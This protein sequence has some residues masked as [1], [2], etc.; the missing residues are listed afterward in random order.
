M[1]DRILIAN[2]GEIACRVIRTARRLGISTVAIYSDADHN[3]VHVGM[4]D[5]A[6]RIGPAPAAQSYLDIATIV[7]AARETGC[8]AVH[9][10]YGFVSENPAFAEA[11]R[12]AGITFIGPGPRAMEIM[13]D[14]IA[15]KRF[16][17]EAG[18]NTVPGHADVISDVE[19]AIRIAGD[20]GYPVMLKA[21]AGGGGKG[22]RVA[23]DEREVREGFPAASNEARSSFGDDRVFIEKF[24]TEPRHIEIQ[25]LADRHGN[26]LHLGERE[27][28]LQ[29]RNQKVIEE[30]PSVAV[31]EQ[32]RMEMGAQA[33]ALARA[34]G[35][36]SAGTVEFI[37]DGE[38]GFYFL[39][40][41]TRLQVEHTVT[42]LITGLDLVEQM[43]RIAA[44]EPLGFGQEEVSFSG[45][46]IEARVYAEDPSRNFL[47]SIGRLVRYQPPRE[48]TH[49][50]L[51][52]RNDGGVDEGGAIS[53]HYD[54]MISKLC[55]HGPTREAA[56]AHMLDALDRFSIVGI[57]HN[58]GFLA[59]LLN[60][61]RWSEGR[62][63]TKLIEEEFP[64]GFSGNEPDD[65]LARDL[66]TVAAAVDLLHRHHMKG[67]DTAHS[68]RERVVAIA[69]RRFDVVSERGQGNQIAVTID[70]ECRQV[71][72]NW[73]A[74]ALTFEATISDRPFAA[75][76]RTG[77]RRIR[78]IRRGTDVVARVMTRREAE[79]I[80]LMPEK[81]PPDTSMQLL[82]PM[83]GTVVTL[84]VEPGQE[85]KAGEVLCVV[86]AMKME[87]NLR[88]E[89][90]ATIARVLVQP[91]DSLAVDAVIM[92]FE[93]GG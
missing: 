81:L 7:A 75:Q 70:G 59:A 39:E 86:E 12:D 74:G 28:S 24:I 83:P 48:G 71:E 73:R 64:D 78:I 80:V 25:V 53:V 36:E 77:P 76:I 57:E 14:K 13:G 38:D 30:A 26:V 52:I 43:I 21:A 66:V 15:S 61:P 46:A 90:D 16:A 55:T 1:F 6:I 32:M 51:T 92:E 87:N 72:T 29:R 18:V 41:N 65:A 27:C 35:Y 58:I 2:R 88:A 31:S 60:H 8:D 82:C 44:D 20:I 67:A 93:P 19:E 62:L 3:A 68:K 33:V 89:R 91:G 10:G 37:T 85:V 63:S 84:A 50:G 23:A 17:T 9:P 40:M 5:E 47:P 45:W 49:N 69:E 79:L 56:S 34:V 4:A 11:L 42:E 54:P 22:M